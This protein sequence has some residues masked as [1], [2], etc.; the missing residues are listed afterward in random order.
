MNIPQSATTTG[1]NGAHHQ[2]G[3][4]SP[5]QNGKIIA[6]S[7]ATGRKLGEVAVTPANQAEAIMARARRAQQPWFWAGLRTRVDALHRFKLAL[8]NNLDLLV[9]TVVAEQGRPAFEGLAEMWAS[10]ESVA[11][12]ANHARE[13]LAVKRPFISFVP[14]RRHWIER[15][16]YGVVLIIA[17]WNFPLIQ[18]LPQIANALVTGNAVVY[19]PSEYATQIAEL[20][21][22]CLREAELP[23]DVFQ[24]AHGGGDLGAAL[25]NAKPNKVCFTGSVPT[26]RK[27]A[28]TAGELLIPVELELGANDA[29]IVLEDADI[30][31][32]AQGVVWGSMYNA[33]QAC[34]SIERLYVA[35][36]I[37]AQFEQKMVEVI[38]AFIKVG[39]GEAMG[40]TMGAITTGMQL[41]VITRHIK[42]AVAKGARIITGGELIEADNGRYYTPTLLTDVT[43]DMLVAKEE[44]FGPVVSIFPFDTDEEAIR[45]VN[46]SPF[47]LTGSV[48]TQDR[49]RGIAICQK[50][51]VGHASVNDHIV[52]ASLPHLP[53]GGTKDTG[54]G[55]ARGAEGMLE[56][57]RPQSFS[58]ERFFSLPTEYFWYPYTPFKYNLLRRAVRALYAPGLLQKLRTFVQGN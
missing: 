41:A 48:W 46:N 52:S 43:P 34:L 11:Y 40:T 42:D 33:G 25:I 45:L 8:R 12:A 9:G 55:S 30:D 37:M 21:A 36:P 56:M 32:T 17:P 26:G 15:R 24:V 49:K 27:V 38:D 18:S 22:R 29:A 57:T 14:H 16:P 4:A 35:R 19:K 44:T 6:T 53:W 47:G 51:E 2:G 3:T 28:A 13:V 54:Y 1:S 20:I 58:V 23:P 5:I 7:P 39:P 10:T 31:R 50:L